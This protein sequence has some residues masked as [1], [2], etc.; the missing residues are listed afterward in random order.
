MMTILWDIDGTILPSSLE[1][2]FF[3]YLRKHH[4]SVSLL[5]TAGAMFRNSLVQWPPSWY[6]M[7]LAY[8]RGLTVDDVE[9]R[10][11]R[12]WEEVIQPTIFPSAVAA[13][14]RLRKKGSRQVLL[15]GAPRMLAERV[16]A[17]L[18]LADL[19]AAEPE[20]DNGAF[21]GG[22]AAPHPRGQ[23]KVEYAEQWL[24][25]HGLSWDNT[26]ALGNHYDDRFLLER[27]TH[28]VAVNPDRRLTNLARE[29]GWPV[30]DPS[31]PDAFVDL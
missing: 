5:T 11:D 21:T 3:A 10:V 30:V 12:C 2:H 15:T 26:M 29:N 18:D 7:K 6:R 14:H 8:L 24:R 17:Y 25:L 13:I 28:P 22:V 9:Y 4:S 1:R 23:R 20:I 27:V 19:I 31:R 16:A